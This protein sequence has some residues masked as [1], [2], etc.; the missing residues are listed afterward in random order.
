MRIRCIPVIQCEN[1]V[2]MMRYA[3]DPIRKGDHSR[4][5]RKAIGTTRIKQRTAECPLD[6][7][8][9]CGSWPWM[10]RTGIKKIAF[11]LIDFFRNT[12][13]AGGHEQL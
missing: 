10:V 4:P 7:G 13:P 3:P 9:E 5:Q 1:T 11:G 2:S 8:S 6:L 12:W